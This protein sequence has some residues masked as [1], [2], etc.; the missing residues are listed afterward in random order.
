MMLR[1]GEQRLLVVDDDPSVV[2][3]LVEMLNQKGYAAAGATEA[4]VALRQIISESSFDLVVADVEMPGMRGLD[5]MAAIHAERADQLVLLITAFGSIDLAMQS[6]RAGACDFL[7]KP[8]RIEELYSAV[9]RALRDRQMRRTA[10]R[11]GSP[12]QDSSGFTFT[13]RSPRMGRVLSL[14]RRAA[15]VGSTVLLTGE[16]GTGKSAIA[17]F[18]HDLSPRRKQPFISINCAALPQTLVESELF[19]VRK[20]AYTDARQHRLGLFLQAHGG[21][22]FLDEIAELPLDIQ[23]KLLQVLEAG[24][25]RPLGSTQEVEADVRLIA[26]TNQPLVKRIEERLFRADLYHRLNVIPLEIPP[27]RERA[28]D[29]DELV[30]ALN[31]QISA[32]LNKPAPALSLEA[33]RWIRAYR[34]PGN[35]RELANTLERA[36]VLSEHDT[37]LLE[38]LVEA[39]QL[40]ESDHFLQEAFARGWTLEEVK[41]AYIRHVLNA[42]GGNKLQAARILGVDR[43]TLYRKLS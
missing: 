24:R 34:W 29:I 13:A 1:Q 19:G 8:F 14:A 22:L 18:I 28:E 2:D 5:L 30:D 39:F 15:A 41:W 10:V 23:P 9:E 36:I 21:T 26:A 20:G 43:S 31:R 33:L 7:A 12:E 3:F 35:V 6:V 42:T 16:S 27:L 4:P 11:I 40:P 32:R 38:D 17:R 37:L 25:V